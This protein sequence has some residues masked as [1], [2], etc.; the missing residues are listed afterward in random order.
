MVAEVGW[1]LV[2]ARM[3]QLAAAWQKKITSYQI[4]IQQQAA[5][6]ISAD[7]HKLTGQSGKGSL[8]QLPCPTREIASLGSTKFTTIS[9]TLNYKVCMHTDANDH[10]AGCFITWADKLAKGE[11]LEVCWL[12]VIHSHRMYAFTI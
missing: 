6:A 4:Q 8:P 3:P 10:P 11:L 9:S 7:L 12:V 5:A 2:V 1:D